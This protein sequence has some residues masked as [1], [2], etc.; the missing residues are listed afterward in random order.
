M[1]KHIGIVACSA[2]GAA[3]CYRTLCAEAPKQMEVWAENV[4]LSGRTLQVFARDVFT[5]G[6]EVGLCHVLVELPQLKRDSRGQQVKENMRDDQR[7]RDAPGPAE[8]QHLRRQAPGHR[9]LQSRRRQSPQR[10]DN[11]DRTSLSKRYFQGSC[12]R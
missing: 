6:L 12:A 5:D 1:A 10:Q 2:E 9:R 11:R 3:L 4:D 8:V 7:T